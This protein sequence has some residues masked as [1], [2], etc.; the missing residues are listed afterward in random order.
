[1]H[2]TLSS[3]SGQDMPSADTIKRQLISTSRK[4]LV[5]RILIGFVVAIALFGLI[6]YFVLPGIVKSQAERILSEQLKRTTTIEKIDIHP[7]SLEA[8]IHGFKMMEPDGTAVFAAFDELYVNLQAQSLF[9][10]GAVVQELRLAKPYVH[11]VHTEGSRYN[12]SDILE[13]IASQPPSDKPTLFSVNNIRLEDGSIQFEDLPEHATHSVDKL[14]IGVPFVSNLPASVEIFVQPALSA[15]V[16]GAPLKLEGRVRPF[17]DT[18]VANIN[19]DVDDVDLTRYVAY[20][21][22]E[23]RFKLPS[24]K[25]DVHLEASFAQPH[26]QPPTL[27]I[28]GTTRLKA[29]E[30]TELDDKPLIKIPQLDVELADS[31]VLAQK[32]ALARVALQSPEIAI[33][34]ARDGSLNLAKLGPPADHAKAALAQAKPVDKPGT[35]QGGATSPAVDLKVA[36]IAI[37]GAVLHVVDEAPEQAFR[38]TVDKL[39]LTVRNFSLPGT[40]PASIELA[41]HTDANE[42]L[43]HSGEL[44]LQPLSAKGKLELGGAALARYVPYVNVLAA[45]VQKGTLDAATEYVFSKDVDQPPQ[46]TLSDASVSLN[47]VALRLQDEK[48]ALIAVDGLGIAQTRFDLRKQEVVIGELASH[49]AKFAV[50]REKDGKLNLARLFKQAGAKSEAGSPD[51]PKAAANEPAATKSAAKPESSAESGKPYA[52]SIKRV[53]IDGWSA[54]LEDRSMARPI[55]T[56]IDPL[57]LSMQDVSTAPDSK[58]SLELAATVN[59]KGKLAASGTAGMSPLHA[60]LK[61][62]FKGVDLLP[63]QPYFTDQ[64]NIL[65]TSAA[66]NTRGQ[67]SLDQGRDGV[68]KGG[69]KGEFAVADLASID[70]LNSQDFLKWKTLSFSGVNA[71]FQPFALTIAQVDLS[72]FYSR[73]IVSQEGRINLQDVARSPESEPKSVTESTPAAE[74]KKS[75]KPKP[76]A[77]TAAPAQPATAGKAGPPIK[78]G[79]VILQRG[80]VNFSDNFI[81]PNYSANLE[82]LGGQVQG[83]S[84]DASSNADVD[85]HGQVNNAPLSIIGKINPLKGDLFLDLKASVK[86][87][88]LAPLT[89]YSGKYVGYGIEKGKLSFDVAYKLENRQLTAQNRLVLDQLTFGGKIESPTATK[90][91]VLLAVS[92]LKDRH[93]VIDVNLPIGG[94]LDDP[95]FSVGGLI[96]RV[97]VNLLTKAITAPFALLGSMFGGGEELSYVEFDLGRATLP[98]DAEEKLEKLSKALS[99]RPA[100]KLEITGHADPARD[101]DGLRRVSIERKVK[102]LKLRDLVKKDES[103]DPASVTVAPEEY[104]ALLKRVYSD[105][106]FTKPRNAIGLQKDIPVEE[107]EALMIA[108]AQVGQDDLAALANQRAQTVKDWLL[109]QGKVPDDRVFL[110]AAKIGEGEAKTEGDVKAKP[111][112]VDFSLK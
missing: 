69:F 9:R 36:E 108:N 20:I 7:Y 38:T 37:V 13:L 85:L 106:K 19:L 52:V 89:P 28:K 84:S 78:V 17:A 91:P 94:S 45:E 10:G 98:K 2:G 27:T 83:L 70:K 46:L 111:S 6:G 1:M 62:D 42:T 44:T 25:L 61:L 26:E 8:S 101:L 95:Q 49:G 4:P 87:M 77:Q 96:V 55:V 99:D 80:R 23:P 34:H 103:V 107:M 104:P 66:L 40:V 15:L 53:A 57:S 47:D 90:L 14:S 18:R 97:I 76:A 93:G 41:A 60:N 43:K 92:L 72:D 68:L 102:A 24:G 71:Q 110:L 81:K 105:E 59:K 112:R 5:R 73:V 32:I 39:D 56:Q 16:N 21:P 67:L 75:D 82:D 109:K 100:L 12:I 79:K 30:L 58:S 33:T 64:I 22:F 31:D 11:L 65:L 88:E 74:E 51:T 86:G 48:Q 50:M 54:R 63:L 3:S 29:L 35:P